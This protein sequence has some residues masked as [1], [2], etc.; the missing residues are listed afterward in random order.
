MSIQLGDLIAQPEPVQHIPLSPTNPQPT[1][2]SL[3]GPSLHL[4]QMARIDTKPI[5]R[6]GVAH[7]KETLTMDLG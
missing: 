1:S 7:K 4:P 2:R 3:Q 5:G 6:I